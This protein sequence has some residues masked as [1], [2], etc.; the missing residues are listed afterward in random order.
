MKIIRTLQASNSFNAV[1]IISAM[2]L[3][4]ALL[5]WSIAGGI[6]LFW[7]LSLGSISLAVGARLSTEHIL[8]L[9]GAKPL[10]VNQ[11]VSLHSAVALLAARANLPLKPRLFYLPSEIPNAF[12]IGSK[13]K[14]VVVVTDGLLRS[15]NF[16]EIVGVIAHEISHIRRNDVWLLRL[17][18]IFNRITVWLSIIGQLLLVLYLPLIVLGGR[19]IPWLA[20]ILLI[21]SPTFTRLLQ[22]YLARSREFDAD[23]DGVGMSGD[24]LGLASALRKMSRHNG[25]S[26]QRI[27][28]KQQHSSMWRTHPQTEK[29]IERILSLVHQR[30]NNEMPSRLFTEDPINR[31]ARW[32][33]ATG[34]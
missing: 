29:R 10:E 27:M 25:G 3:L 32:C 6:G 14:S 23:L 26:I 4:L 24:P 16:R 8:R 5:G 15:L 20:V 18:D 17:A 28:R 30:N 12:A 21:V 1:I 19:P 11:F 7:A 2:A 31:R 13:S 33:Q 34:C 22:L 9:Y